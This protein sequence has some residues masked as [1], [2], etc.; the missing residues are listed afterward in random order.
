MILQIL[1]PHYKE[2]PSEMIPLLDTIAIQ[3]GVDFLDVGM[4]IVYDGPEATPLPEREWR[5]KYPFGIRF[6]HAPHGGVSSARNTALDNATAEYVMFCDADDMFCSSIGLHII[7]HTIEGGFDALISSFLEEV[8]KGDGEMVYVTH[9]EDQTFVHGKVF[10]RKYLI[11]NGIRFCPRLKI[12]ED[13][14]FNV[15]SQ[16]S[17]TDM[18]YCK[19]PFYLWKWRDNSI[20]RHDPDYMLKTYP[21]L[22][23]SNDALVDDLLARGRDDAATELVLF[24]V[25]DA[26]YTLNKPEWMA[27]TSAEYR[28]AVECRIA[29]YYRDRRKMWESADRQQKMRASAGIRKRVIEEGMDIET[30]TIAEWLRHIEEKF[31]G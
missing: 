30:M 18:K 13:S 27:K 1:V 14:Y 16:I 29:D 12:H 5:T 10:R 22:I 24:M 31:K 6:V 11:E 19:T 2:T 28:D 20:C 21:Q 26:Y 23:D 15:L 25:W 3:Q 7:S 4:I 9:N 17:T 8:Q